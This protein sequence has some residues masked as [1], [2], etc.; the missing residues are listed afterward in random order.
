[1]TFFLNLVQVCLLSTKCLTRSLTLACPL[2]LTNTGEMEMND[3]GTGAGCSGQN[4][5]RQES[6]CCDQSTKELWRVRWPRASISI[7]VKWDSYFKS[8]V[9]LKHNTLCSWS[10]FMRRGV[11]CQWIPQ[12]SSAFRRK[13]VGGHRAGKGKKRSKGWNFPQISSLCLIPWGALEPKLHLSLSCIKAKKLGF[14]SPSRCSTTN[15]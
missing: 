4:N 5:W 8:L 11:T 12:G 9:W 6:R 3:L 14:H 10:V 1:M 7:S 2:F 13:Q 15:G